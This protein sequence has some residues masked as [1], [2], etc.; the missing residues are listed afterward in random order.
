MRKTKRA[1]FTVSTSLQAISFS[2][3]IRNE[4]RRTALT[5]HTADSFDKRSM[6]EAPKANAST[7]IREGYFTEFAERVQALNPTVPI[8]LSGGFR[9]RAG[10][11]DAISSGACA[12]VGLGRAAVLEPELPARVL[13][14]P[15]Y[16]DDAAL[17]ASHVV[18][19]QWLAKAIPVKVVGSGLV[20]QFFYYNMR[21]IGRGLRCQPDASIPFIV[22]V[23]L[24]ESLV[25]GVT[26]GVQKLLA[27][28][29]GPTSVIYS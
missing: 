15:E 5:S 17:A 25:S 7:R 3:W 23:G 27:V 24:W 10:M 26:R 29:G 4:N 2:F 13:L 12:L 8:Q 1:S 22:A 14:N 18:R 19:G 21:R 11:A 20:I 16:A 28:F 9:S 6:T